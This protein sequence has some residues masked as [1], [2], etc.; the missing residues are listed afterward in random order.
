MQH[1]SKPFGRIE[2]F[3]H[4]QQRKADGISQQG[5]LFRVGAVAC[6]MRNCR[7]GD[8]KGQWFFAAGLAGPQHVQADASRY[9]RQPAAQIFDLGRIAADEA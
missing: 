7:L 9:G 6:L 1:K 2:L 4:H 3:E 8:A 5:V